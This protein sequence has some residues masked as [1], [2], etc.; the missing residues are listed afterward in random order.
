MNYSIGKKFQEQG[1]FYLVWVIFETYETFE[2]KVK[3]KDK[4]ANL[5]LF[6]CVYFN[7]M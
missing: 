4:Y 1:F 2:Y 3:E 6:V 7:V 5:D